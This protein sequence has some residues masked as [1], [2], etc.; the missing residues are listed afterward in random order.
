VR[1]LQVLR[2]GEDPAEQREEGDAHGKRAD[3]EAGAAEE[4]E[5]E[6]RLGC[7]PLP[8]QEEGEEHGG[9]A[10][11]AQ[12]EAAQPALVRCLDHRV[13][14]HAEAGR[15]E[16]GA[17]KVERTR[18]R[19]A[20]LRQKTDAEQQRGE[21]ERDVHEE[22]R[23]PVEPLEQQPARERPQPDA[24]G[25]QG[26]PDPDRLAALLGREDVGDDRQRRRHDHR[27]ADSHQ[28]AHGYQLPGGVGDQRTEARE[29]EDRDARLESAFAAEAV[30]ERAEDQ[31]EAGED[32]EIGVDHPLQPGRGR[33]E[34]LL[35]RRERNIQDRVVEPDDDQAE[36]EHAERLPA[37]RVDLCSWSDV[38]DGS[39]REDRKR[40][41]VLLLF[42]AQLVKSERSL[43]FLEG[44]HAQG[45]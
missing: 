32:E 7:A 5:V 20:A 1:E 21:C 33:V 13:D 28:G 18:P 44:E 26:C 6:H 12:G 29:A 30:P 25:G 17:G 27:R 22:D 11:Q 40:M 16:R 34:L 42:G 35:K 38:H 2:E 23:R 19:V 37:H 24:E 3:A 9:D 10:K 31:Q 36:R 45:Q 14:E 8:P 39:Q 43:Y 4:A 41:H 15:G